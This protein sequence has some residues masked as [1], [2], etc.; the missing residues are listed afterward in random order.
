MSKP[1]SRLPDSA[2]QLIPGWQ[3]V[4]KRNCFRCYSLR[5]VLPREGENLGTAATAAGGESAIVREGM[6]G[7]PDES[8]RLVLETLLVLLREGGGYKVSF[9]LPEL[10]VLIG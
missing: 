4:M 2:G 5:Q 3:G 6:S 1:D 8:G 10:L 9:M 7:C